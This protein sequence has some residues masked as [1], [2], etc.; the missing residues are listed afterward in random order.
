MNWRS[1]T[2]SRA[3]KRAAGAAGRF[4]CRQRP[5]LPTRLGADSRRDRK[6]A[7]ALGGTLGTVARDYRDRVPDRA[8]LVAE[9]VERLRTGLGAEAVVLNET[10]LRPVR[11][12]TTL[13]R[14]DLLATEPF[15]NQLVH[16][17]LPDDQHQVDALLMRL[18]TQAGPLATAPAPL[19]PGTRS[20]LTTGYLA[21]AYFGGHPRQAAIPSA[22]PSSTS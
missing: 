1:A 21:D 17:A 20:L 2:R 19:P 22:K 13:T 12:G 15:D 3:W 18:S 16:V 5:L 8:E 11:L 4:S 7:S 10:A 9:V 14:G 6:P